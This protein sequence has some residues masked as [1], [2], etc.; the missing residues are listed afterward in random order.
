M[1]KNYKY[2]MLTAAGMFLGL[3]M[4]NTVLADETTTVPEPASVNDT[5]TT[6]GSNV[7][8]QSCETTNT[9]ESEVQDGT[10]IIQ[11]AINDGK[12]IDAENANLDSG[13]NAQIY[14][15]NN[16]NAQYWSIST[17]DDGTKT[18]TNINS[19]KVLDV[20]CGQA[21]N[22]N[23]VQLW[24]SCNSTGQKWNLL[25]N[26][27]GYYFIQSAIN[28]NYVLDLD[29][30]N[31]TN[32]SNIQLYEMNKNS[33]GQMWKLTFVAQ[34]GNM[35]QEDLKNLEGKVNITSDSS[36]SYALNVSGGSTD[37]GANIELY[38]NSKSRS[39]LWNLSVDENGYVTFT[40]DETNSV[41][42]L[43]NGAVKN[44]QNIQLYAG[45][46]N[47]AQKWVL[48][49]KNGSYEIRS[50]YNLSYTLDISNGSI[51]NGSNI[52]LFQVNGSQ[53]QRFKIYTV[54]SK[55]KSLAEM[56]LKDLEDSLFI[57][58]EN[59]SNAKKE[60]ETATTVYNNTQSAYNAALSSQ[61]TAAVSVETAKNELASAKT[62]L[63]NLETQLTN[64]QSSYDLI[65]KQYEE[66]VAE[67]ATINEKI[68][69][70]NEELSA[71]QT[72]YNEVVNNSK[73]SLE[74]AQEALKAF[75][76][77]YAVQLKQFSEGTKGYFDSI[78]AT[79]ASDVVGN[80]TGVVAGYTELGTDATSIENMKKAIAYIKESNS[81]REANGLDPLNV[82]MYLM[83]VS[84]VNAN[85]SYK[86][87]KHSH[88]RA[89]TVSEN[90]AWG[91]YGEAG[92]SDSPFRGWYDEEKAYVDF[93]KQYLA[94]NPNA[95]TSEVDVAAKEAGVYPY[96]SG[97]SATHYYSIV[98][99][100]NKVTGYSFYG[101]TSVQ[102]FLAWPNSKD[103]IMTVEEFEQSLNSYIATMNNLTSQHQALQE[104][105][106]NATSTVDLDE[107]DNEEAI[108]SALILVN[109]KTTEINDLKSNLTKL[110]E[111]KESLESN[112]NSSY[113]SLTNI[114]NKVAKT[115]KVVDQ[116]ETSLKNAE[117]NLTAVKN[118][119]ASLNVKLS[120]AKNSLQSAKDYESSIQ[121]I[122][123]KLNEN[124]EEMHNKVSNMY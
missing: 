5:N 84:E 32:G 1:K 73:S 105:V 31:T 3:G 72:T 42:D 109:N 107:E 114:T 27:N 80:P 29:C 33:L 85:W 123:S 47:K 37:N 28:N 116:K 64:A 36:D 63:K 48:V 12:V 79:L 22:K 16:S 74:L 40:S 90:I 82:S 117:K 122:I 108:N 91:Y 113:N 75:E 104:T 76:E 71:A 83:A 95:T 20:N 25:N 81:L 66:K 70:A 77:K 61:N 23:N 102:D 96:S 19:G 59:L 53:A 100:R 88:S 87:S 121:S 69:K 6:V 67:I 106:Q 30:G 78:G 34:I 35:K 4:Y 15:S 2:A 39:E 103:V 7:N 10:Y 45:N 118:N 65:S 57:E 54:T 14:E 120:S 86:T 44:N 119:V 18:I 17:N 21:Y 60:V 115:Q 124:I 26:G 97:G 112:K 93:Q 49:K 13:T 41:I 52:Q 9:T 94:S 62:N 51:S 55:E 11:S 110:N 68:T 98:L 111:E 101:N 46:G 38:S 50:A 89:Y 8:T 56:E 92:S 99:K 58:Q 24:E 43:S